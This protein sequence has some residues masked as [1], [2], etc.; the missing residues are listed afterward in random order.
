MH[1]LPLPLSADVA[2][3]RDRHASQVRRADKL[4]RADPDATLIAD[5]LFSPALQLHEPTLLP[6]AGYRER[7]D[8]LAAVWDQVRRRGVGRGCVQECGV[9]ADPDVEPDARRAVCSVF[10]ASYLIG[11]EH[12]YTGS[13]P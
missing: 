3:A 9:P 1:D 7:G 5:L 10:H 12:T 6:R 4:P 2:P 8:G 13:C 11:S